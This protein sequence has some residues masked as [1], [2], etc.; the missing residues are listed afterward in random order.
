MS[1]LSLQE[2]TAYI[3]LP[4]ID[5]FD[6]SNLEE[7]FREGACHC[8]QRLSQLFNTQLDMDLTKLHVIPFSWILGQIQEDQR[9]QTGVHCRVTGDIRGELYL[10]LSRKCARGLIQTG[11]KRG[12]FGSLFFSRL[13][14]SVLNEFTNIMINTFWQTL[15]QKFNVR[16]WLTPPAT[17]N[18]PSHSLMLAG[19]IYS[20]ERLVLLAE[21]ITVKPRTDLTLFFLP[22]EDSFDLFLS[23]LR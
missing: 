6:Q 12:G 11:L 16:W 19:R 9:F 21:I 18:R 20:W 3:P 17:L 8:A 4:S 15:S 13:E 1:S 7:T 23:Q 22:A 2:A 10:F 5:P 14:E